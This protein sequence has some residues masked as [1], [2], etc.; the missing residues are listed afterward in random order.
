MLQWKLCQGSSSYNRARGAVE[1]V[2]TVMTMWTSH[3][4]IGLLPAST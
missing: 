3:E 1:S 2:S 4:H